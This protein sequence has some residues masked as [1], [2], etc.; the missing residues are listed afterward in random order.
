M[1]PKT[2]DCFYKTLRH[3][4]GYNKDPNILCFFLPQ[5]TKMYLMLSLVRSK[6][7]H[8][9]REINNPSH[10]VA[11]IGRSLD[12]TIIRE[13]LS[14]VNHHVY[15]SRNRVRYRFLQFRSFA[16]FTLIP[17]RDTPNVS[18]KTGAIFGVQRSRSTSTRLLYSTFDLNLLSENLF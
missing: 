11:C 2:G 13:S 3:Y 7:N 5:Q 1:L 9:H 17:E 18:S 12:V 6:N 4:R 10:I 15:V 8:K 14:R 16:R